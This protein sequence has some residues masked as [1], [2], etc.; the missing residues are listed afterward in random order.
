MPGQCVFSCVH[1]L[2]GGSG[3]CLDDGT[4]LCDDDRFAS[5]DAFGNSSCVLRSALLTVFLTAAVYELSLTAVLTFNIRQ[6]WQLPRSARRGRRS[7]V[8]Q[9]LTLVSW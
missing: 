6:H 4:C 1:P 2:Y 8:W 9:R 7:T 5:T 3:T